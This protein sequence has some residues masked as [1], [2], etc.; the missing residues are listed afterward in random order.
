MSTTKMNAILYRRYGSAEVLDFQQV[1]K[2]EAGEDD[3]L[4]QILATSVNPADWHYMTGKPYFMRLMI[5]LRKPKKI[6]LGVDMAGRVEAVGKNVTKFKVGDE[7]FGWSSASFAEYVQVTEKAIVSKP[8][9]VSYEQGAAVAI[10]ALTALQGLRDK[11]NLQ[12]GHNVLINGAAGG[13]GT[14]AVQIAKALG[15]QVTG[16]CSTRNVEM[17]RSIGSDHVIDY[18]KENFTN[19]PKRYDLILDTIGNHSLAASKRALSPSGKLVIVGGPVRHMIGAM[20]RL[21]FTTKRT[22]GFIA[23]LT[24]LDLLTMRDLLESGKVVPVIDRNYSLRDTSDALT[25]LSQGHAQGKV[26]LRPGTC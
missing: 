8:S 18:T 11:G 10:A 7:V 5:G 23:K 1:E 12:E 25:Y 16:V 21:P 2:P 17:V 13:V 9:N 22:V 4:V 26:V 24:N 19:G 15:A 6:T 20:L 3:I 14:F